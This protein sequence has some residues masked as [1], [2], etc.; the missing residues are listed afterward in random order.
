M[1]GLALASFLTGSKAVP[2]TPCRFCFTEGH[3]LQTHATA[4]G[5]KEGAGVSAEA[6]WI[7]VFP[8]GPSHTAPLPEWSLPC[9]GRR[10]AWDDAV[11]NACVLDQG[12]GQRSLDD[13]KLKWP[14]QPSCHSLGSE[15][16]LGAG[17]CSQHCLFQVLWHVVTPCRLGCAG[18]ESPRALSFQP[19][20]VHVGEHRGPPTRDF[21]LPRTD[22]VL[23]HLTHSSSR[24]GE[25]EL[26]KEFAA[27]LVLF[28]PYPLGLL[29]RKKKKVLE[30]S[31]HV[32]STRA[33]LPTNLHF[34]GRVKKIF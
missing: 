32:N 17:P 4:C 6:M 10:A 27:S 22:S 21:A 16:K 28:P 8:S 13:A 25:G 5:K 30:M 11:G 31:C 9:L 1:A 26:L 18:A 23:R 34:S 2:A 12:P 14:F 19:S 20:C 15:Q 29:E 24:L 7:M 33:D 3:L